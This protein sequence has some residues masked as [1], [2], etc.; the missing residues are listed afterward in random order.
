[1][2]S[3][4]GND[5]LINGLIGTLSQVKYIENTPFIGTKMQGTFVLEDEQDT[6]ENVNMDLKLFMEGEPF[7]NAKN[8][9]KIPKPM[10][11]KEFDY[12]YTITTHKAQGSEYDKV[13]VLEEFLRGGQHDRWLYTA[14][15]RAAKKLVIIRNYK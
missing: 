9:K 1:M 7:I 15:T 3:T 5:T 11:P 8:F 12:G 13:L 10:R 6:F 14:C 4:S 2:V